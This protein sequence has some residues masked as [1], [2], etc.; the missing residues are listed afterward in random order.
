MQLRVND[1][2]DI[3]GFEI[4]DKVLIP[5]VDIKVEIIAIDTDD[6]IHNIMID[7]SEEDF[8]E[9]NVLNSGLSGI[10]CRK[11]DRRKIWVR[12]ADI[13]HITDDIELEL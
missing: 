7:V 9:K 13:Q 11:D 1:K 8:N 6:Y 10:Y 5:S 12:S 2:H 3:D 4:G